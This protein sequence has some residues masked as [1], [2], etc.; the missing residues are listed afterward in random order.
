MPTIC[1]LC[2]YKIPD[3]KQKCPSCNT[4]QTTEIEYEDHSILLKDVKSAEGDRIDVEFLNDVWGGG[5]VRTSCTLFGGQPGAGKSTILLQVLDI[6]CKKTNRESIYIATE[7]ALPEIKLRADRLKINTNI[8]L[9]PAMSGVAD[10]G[11]ILMRH[12]P[13]AIVVDSLQGLIGPNEQM[14]VELLTN[15]KKWSVTLEAPSIIVSH[16]N[17]DG[18]YAGLMTYQ[19]AVDVLLVL[20]PNDDG[21]RT[22]EVQKNRYGRAFIESEFEMTEM[23]LIP[24]LGD[25]ED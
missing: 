7:E 19:H 15:M 3:N 17:K 5:L 24:I 1:R 10:P 18:D 8:R 4:W 20:S 23:G 2:F 16:V 21:T 25:D 13:A 11:Q 9:V 14:G 12:K 6:V 22:L